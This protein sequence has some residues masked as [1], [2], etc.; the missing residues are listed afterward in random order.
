[1]PVYDQSATDPDSLLATTDHYL[2][3][4]WCK[5]CLEFFEVNL[6]LGICKWGTLGQCQ[7][8]LTESEPRIPCKSSGCTFHNWFGEGVGK[9]SSGLVFSSSSLVPP[10]APPR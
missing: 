6:E 1:M 8:P 5:D 4:R 7:A 2:F 10:N 3:Y 9:D